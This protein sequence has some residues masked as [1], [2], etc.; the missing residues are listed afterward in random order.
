MPLSTN[1]SRLEAV[2]FIHFGHSSRAWQ[3]CQLHLEL[4]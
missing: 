1:Y 2:G 4:H 3:R